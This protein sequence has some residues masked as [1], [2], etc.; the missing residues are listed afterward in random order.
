MDLHSK[1]NFVEINFISLI[2]YKFFQIFSLFPNSFLNHSPTFVKTNTLPF[3]LVILPLSLAIAP[4]IPY[5]HTQTLKFTI[6]SIS[7]ELHTGSMQQ[8]PKPMNLIIPSLTLIYVSIPPI[9]DP[10]TH[11]QVVLKFALV[12]I[13]VLISDLAKTMQTVVQEDTFTG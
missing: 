11:F 3:H 6:K 10:L 1:I 13:T 12:F 8:N 7:I 9:C 4:I 2:F 5:H